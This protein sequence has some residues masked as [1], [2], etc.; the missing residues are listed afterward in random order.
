MFLMHIMKKMHSF[1]QK[2]GFQS[3]GL[4]T[5]VFLYTNHYNKMNKL[6]ASPYQTVNIMIQI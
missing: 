3:G 2:K 5:C 6:S 4:I 1:I